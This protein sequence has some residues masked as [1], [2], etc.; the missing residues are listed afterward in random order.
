MKRPILIAVLSLGALCPA[1]AADKPADKEIVLLASKPSHGPGQHEHNAD[2]LLFAK[3]HNGI[4][5]IHAVTYLNGDWPETPVFERAD[6]IF[7]D[8]DGAEG[9]PFFQ[10]DHTGIINR[11]A[12]RGVGLMFYHW[13][14]EPPAKS[15]HQEMLDWT[16][17]YFELN[18]SVNPLFDASFNALPNHPITRGVKPFHIR[19]EWYYNNRFRD[20]LRGFTPIL[21]T[22]PPADT[23]KGDGP[24]SGNPDVRSKAG[25]PQFVAWAGERQDGGRSMSFCGGHYHSNLGDP[26]FRRIV[27][28]GILWVAKA[29]VP[30]EGF[31]V[32]VTPEDLTANLDPKQMRGGG[33]GAPAGPSPAP[34]A[35]PGQRP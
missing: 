26:N 8:A 1:P 7:L 29:E 2:V 19:D 18:Y 32:T 28:N 3:W 15:G 30:P 14:T 13:A 4:P 6:E 35:A 9:H 21:I 25:Q 12:K 23:V 34:N 24:R 16:A 17:G 11:A 22:T 10:G 5:G 33:R 27:M 31:E 20:S